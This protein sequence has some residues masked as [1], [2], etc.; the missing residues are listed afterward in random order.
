MS[1]YS[2]FREVYNMKAYFGGNYLQSLL[3]V[4]DGISAA[5]LPETLR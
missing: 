1:N 4:D 5:L 2:T 3:D